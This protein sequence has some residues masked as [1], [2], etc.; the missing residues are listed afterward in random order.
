MAGLRFDSL[1]DMP[2]GMRKLAVRKVVAATIKTVSM[3][4]TPEEP[5]KPNK[6]RNVEVEVDGIHF[7]SKKEARRF[8]Y[9]MQAQELG[10][11]EDLRLQVDFTLQEGFKKPDGEPVLRLDAYHVAGTFEEPGYSYGF[12]WLDDVDLN[13]TET[14]GN[15]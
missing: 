5:K 6:Y 3:D 8:A 11:I 7:Q 13:I 14:W 10:V 12:T 15:G 4:A 9:L 1:A 2:E